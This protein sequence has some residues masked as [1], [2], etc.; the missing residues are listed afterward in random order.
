MDDLNLAIKYLDKGK[1]RDA[2]SY[3]NELLKDEVAG[4]DLKVAT[5]RF[6]NQIRKE[7]KFP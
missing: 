6:M 5:L 3:A 7:Q 1:S 4:F 2:L